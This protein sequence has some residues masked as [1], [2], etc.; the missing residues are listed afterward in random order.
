MAHD[1]EFVLELTREQ[2]EIIEA[3]FANDLD[4]DNTKIIMCG[5]GFNLNCRIMA[6]GTL[7]GYYDDLCD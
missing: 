3:A 7:R 5:I 2:S 6:A 1:K 4:Y